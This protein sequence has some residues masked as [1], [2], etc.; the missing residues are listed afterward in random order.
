[1]VAVFVD[2]GELVLGNGFEAE[3]VGFVELETELVLGNDFEAEPVVLGNDFEAEPVGLV[4]FAGWV[5]L[6]AVTECEAAEQT[7][8]AVAV[9]IMSTLRVSPT[10]G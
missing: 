6:K 7:A 8:C 4:E 9:Q 1:M 5:V 10:T 3:P 2:G